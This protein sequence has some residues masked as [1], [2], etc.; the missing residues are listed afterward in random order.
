MTRE[1]RL[2]KKIEQG[3]I[4]AADELIG[5]Y[6][7]EI[8]RYCL[9]HAPN[10]AFAEDA[11]QETFLKALRYFDR[12]THRGKFRAFLYQIAANTCIDMS[13]KIRTT[14]MS[15]EEMQTEP[16]KEETGYE[17]VQ[18]DMA[19][20]QMVKGLP[21]DQ[22]EIVLLRFGQDLTMRE[23]AEAVNI[24]LRTVQT[25]LRSALKKLKKE[26]ERGGVQ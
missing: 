11:A 9:W 10:R 3:D 15:L 23:I 6:Y 18:S 4:R 24:P 1:D 13:R 17:N 8:L 7:P 5:I 26:I 25:R 16:A 22:Q 20:Q 21:P 12:Y 2:I 14:E 19:L